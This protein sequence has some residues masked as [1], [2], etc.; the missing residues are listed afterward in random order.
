MPIRTYLLDDHPVVRRGLRDLLEYEDD[1]EV[2]GQAGTAARAVPEILEL[3]PDV[4]I[5]DARLPDGHGIEVCREVRSADPGV[6]CL[7][8]TSYDDDEAR[9]A[10]TLAGAA[11]YV[12]KQIDE[13]ALLRA[14]RAVNSGSSLMDPAVAMRVIERRRRGTARGALGPLASLSAQEAQILSLITEGLTNR[15]IGQR[16]HLAE[17]T[18]KNHV[19]S[20]LG[21]LGV[22]RRTQA[23]LLVSC[24]TLER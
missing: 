1:I 12:L 24:L 15:E 11:G 20:L 19:T 2:V 17:K 16:L 9:F 18:V 10:A 22:Q 13:S 14:I 7:I 5:L 8:L 4:A 23:A 21:K 3:S 6:K